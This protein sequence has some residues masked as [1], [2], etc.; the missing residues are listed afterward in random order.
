LPDVPTLRDLGYDFAINSGIGIGGPAGI[1]ED[2]LKILEKAFLE[3]TE[4]PEFK[5]VTERLMMPTL[6]YDQQEFRRTLEED[7]KVLGDLLEKM[8]LQK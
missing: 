5:K 1:P 6:Q 4:S 3:A 8:G 2:R 7:S